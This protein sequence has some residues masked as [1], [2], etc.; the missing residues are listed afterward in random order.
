MPPVSV[1]CHSGCGVPHA[2]AA[3][4]IIFARPDGHLCIKPEEKCPEGVTRLMAIYGEMAIYGASLS[5]S[6]S[7]AIALS[8]SPAPR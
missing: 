6:P 4:M 1:S 2:A 7:A 8:A 5:A 3:P